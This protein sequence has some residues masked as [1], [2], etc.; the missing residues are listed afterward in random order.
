[1]NK[2]EL[3]VFGINKDT[4]LYHGKG[5]EQ[6]ANTGYYGR[7]GIFELLVVDDEIRKLILKN[8]DSNQ[9]RE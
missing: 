1:M 5:C 9:I 7:R 3:E 2:E 6:C 8:A 4:I